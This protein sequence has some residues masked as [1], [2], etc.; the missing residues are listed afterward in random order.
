MKKVNYYALLLAAVLSVLLLASCGD[1]DRMTLSQLESENADDV[2]GGAGSGLIT[3]ADPSQLS[4]PDQA[5]GVSSPD[6]VISDPLQPEV[7]VVYVCGCVRNPG[8]YELPAGS[9]VCDGLEAAG[10]FSEGAD[11]KRI[12]LAGMLED[13]DM[14][15]FPEVGEELA[16]GASDYI[17]GREEQSAT[18]A[19][20]NINTAGEQALCTL[21]GIGSSKAQ[22][23]ISYREEHGS[24]KDIKEIMNVNGIGE[25][26]FNQIKDLIRV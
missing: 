14:V 7:I 19:L 21:P 4:A 1:P 12:N 6:S 24:F 16:E 23:I 13:G 3:E 25:N 5:A 2:S 17:T 15:F 20:I 9:R 22:A 11:E 18:G 10:G 26:L 8:V